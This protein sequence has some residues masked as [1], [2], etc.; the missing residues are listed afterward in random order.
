MHHR[1]I[2]YIC[3][4][5]EHVYSCRFGTL[6]CDNERERSVAGI[7]ERTRSLWDYLDEHRC[8]AFANS[9][10]DRVSDV[11][12]P[13]LPC[14]LRRVSLWTD[15]HLA[16]SLKACAPCLPRG[17]YPFVHP[18]GGESLFELE[19]STAM[20][21]CERGR[22]VGIERTS[23]TAHSDSDDADV[24]VVNGDS[25]SSSVDSKSLS[26]ATQALPGE[27]ESLHCIIDE[28]DAALHKALWSVGQWRKLAYDQQNEISRLKQLLDK[29]K[30]R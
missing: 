7:Y 6:L 30:T 29:T 25:C 8:F 10:F 3:A 22:T 2:R 18:V 12:L 5:A 28:R 13:P 19:A 16:F 14:I 4:I 24:V 21:E 1:S 17:L 27:L 15:Y 26:L 11:F 20:K 9:A 23:P